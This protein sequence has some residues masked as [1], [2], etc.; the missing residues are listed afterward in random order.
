M[1]AAFV[2]LVQPLFA[3]KEVATLTSALQIASEL[4]CR[5]KF[6]EA[7]ATLD[8]LDKSQETVDLADLRGCICLEQGKFEEAKKAFDAA[9]AIKYEAFAPKIHAADLLFRQKKYDEARAAYESLVQI[10]APMWPEYARFGVLL[11]NLA[12]HDEERARRVV[13]A[14]PFPSG[15]PVYYY[16]QAA[17]EFAHGN[18]SEA[19]RWIASA[20][21]M[22]PVNKTSWFDRGLYQQGWLKKKPALAVDSFL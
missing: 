6:D 20:K 7:L 2:F 22:F 3:Q 18:E 4:Y 1:L 12:E 15:S 16:A 21:K 10:Q 19:K 8:R 14:I 9:R 13:G 11:C 17:W 5:E